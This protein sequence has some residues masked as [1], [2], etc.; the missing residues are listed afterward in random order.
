M[1]TTRVAAV[2]IN[3][4]LGVPERVLPAIDSWCERAAAEKVDL[5][6]FP[7]L[8]VHGHCTPNTWELAER[9]PDGPSTARLVE[10]AKRL[11][12]DPGGVQRVPADPVLTREL[13]LAVKAAASIRE[14]FWNIWAGGQPCIQH[15]LLRE[16]KPPKNSGGGSQSSER[17]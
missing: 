11:R 2:S 1:R 5:V 12:S 6:L 3:G 15:R 17:C 16:K 13:E 9:V 14:R 8:V 7:E 10:I 4:F